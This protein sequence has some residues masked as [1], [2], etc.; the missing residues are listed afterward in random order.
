LA[1]AWVRGGRW[2]N[3]PPTFVEYQVVTAFGWTHQ[4]F[5]ET[6]AET[7][8]RLLDVDRAAKAE[9]NR[10]AQAAQ[11]AARNAGR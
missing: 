8:F 10:R 9:E 11:E 3:L 7:M 5:R 4:Q 6:D 2:I 1:Q